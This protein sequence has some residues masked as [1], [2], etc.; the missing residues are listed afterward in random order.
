MQQTAVPE[1]GHT[2][3]DAKQPEDV[4]I[5][6]VCYMCYNC[7]GIK[8]RRVNGIIRK[9]EGDPDNP[10]N[11]GV[12]CAK[13]NAGIM[14]VYSPYRLKKPLVRTNPR[15]GVNEDPRWREISF[16]EATSMLVAKLRKVKE[17]DPRRLL[18]VSFDLQ[19]AWSLLRNWAAAFGTPHMF[20][21]GAQYFCGP[22]VHPI[23]HLTQGSFIAQ[24]D[25]DFC[26]YLM[27]FG[28][29][30]GF[31][32]NHF[33]MLNAP[34]LADAQ[35]RGMKLVVI[36]PMCTNAGAKADEWIGIKPG[37][38]AELALS[39]ANVLVNELGVYDAEF[40][41]K[42]TNAPYLVGEDDDG[43]YVRSSGERKPLVWDASRGAAVAFDQV[44]ATSSSSLEIG[45]KEQEVL[46]QKAETTFQRLKKHLKRYSPE[47]A[48]KITDVPA[49]A[50]R[51]IAREF[52][53][54]A[55]IGKTIKL[56]GVEL[57]LRPVC[58][59][60]YRGPSGHRHSMLN[61]LSL[62]LLN[63]LVGAIDVPGGRLGCTPVGPWWSVSSDAD[64][65][66]L[67][68]SESL[69][70]TGLSSYPARKVAKP[71][72]L[73]LSELM[74]VTNG[75]GATLIENLLH[76]ERYNVGYLPD[77][78]IIA[79]ANMMKNIANPTE[80]GEA[81]KKIGFIVCFSTELNETSLFADLVIPEANYLERLDALPNKPNEFIAPGRGSWYWML[82]QPVVAPPHGVKHWLQFLFDISDDLGITQDLNAITNARLHL[83]DKW[84]L[85]PDIRYEWDEIAD[86]WLK[87]WFGEEHD[88]T[89]FKQNGFYVS[90]RK[91][92]E[93]A[94]PRHFLKARA[95][96]Y[97]EHFIEAGR[98]VRQ[99][100]DSLGISWDTSDYQPLPDWKPCPAYEQR[101]KYDLFAINYKLPTHTFSYTVS[102]SW[103]V[104]A[105]SE[106]K[107][108]QFGIIMHRRVAERLQISEGDL[109]NVESEYGYSTSGRAAIT[110]NI[111][112]ETIAIPAGG[113]RWLKG[114]EGIGANFNGLL[115]HSTD[116]IDTVCGA[117]DACV[118]VSLSK[119]V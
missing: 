43:R 115:P 117:L 41:K 60:H 61:G 97:C 109:V 31:V 89:Y 50:I 96:I 15:K 44:V 67:L 4:W 23:L 75:T 72:T 91:R 66:L 14:S 28:T 54:A 113:G 87:S 69:A 100:A 3:D 9:I 104:E 65:M 48:S 101:G 77:V 55:S 73:T 99:V 36:D 79:R 8:V 114:Q 6:S 22:G 30:T 81:L 12:L 1:V 16:E 32:V 90:G 83:Q 13:G 17:T 11:R 46:G 26:N 93:E 10:I 107:K 105:V 111:H 102:N 86:R 49:D 37:T 76:P 84:A 118:R 112:P 19:V 45:E 33:P 88:L 35:A 18:I 7:C 2:S 53:E 25:L 24:P 56:D 51:R 29:Q 47:S 59:D 94:Y 85:A 20:S 92:I 103:L 106:N 98:D 58:V 38:D 64:G 42:H 71:Q 74:P 119:Q 110:E 82:R 108:S 40:L 68:P 78:A 27:L 95:P 5:K 39:L 57:P 80:I 70:V 21:G 62:Q 52:G 34:K 63:L 116:R